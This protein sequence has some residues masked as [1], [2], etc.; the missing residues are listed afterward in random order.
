[1]IEYRIGDILKTD[2]E[3]L[4]NTVNCVG[5]M[6]RGIALQFKNA[7][8]E[9]FRA[10]AAACQH[11]EV[12]PGRMFVFET[13]T[14]TNPRYIINFPTK[15]HWRGKSRLEDIEAGLTALTHEIRARHIHSIAI[16]PLGSGLGGLNWADVR[17]RIEAALLGFNNV[18]VIV[19]EPSGAPDAKTMAR[20]RDVPDMTPGRA[21]LVGLMYRYLGGLMDPFVTLLEVHKLL[22]FMQEAGERLKLRYVQGVYG[23]YAENLSHVLTRV[24]GHLLSGYADGG[25]NPEKQLDLVPGAVEETERFLQDYAETLARLYRVTDLVDGF[26]TPFGLELLATVHWVVQSLEAKSSE[27]VVTT[28]YGWNDRKRRFS[29]DQILLALDVLQSKGWLAT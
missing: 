25:D 17:G 12:R 26:E 8:P 27:E 4:V 1:M 24:E 16:P 2:A 3:A 18:N 10:Y 28:T 7:F 20:S 11:E 14:F 29:Q 13:G 15:R 19:F 22:Y 9:N 21:A 5:I 6:G 23:P